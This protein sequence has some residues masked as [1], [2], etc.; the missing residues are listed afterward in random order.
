MKQLF[1]QGPYANRIR[2]A[3][4]LEGAGTGPIVTRALGSRRFRLTVTGPGG[5]SW[6]DHG[7]P[8]PI[9]Q[10]AQA[11]TALST[12]PLPTQ[13]RTTLNVG[14]ISGGTSINSIPESATALLDLRS[15]DPATLTQTESLLR[16]TL[17]RALQPQSTTLDLIGDRPAAALP[18]D[19]SLL[20][21]LR[22]TDRHL[23]LPTELRIGST[24]AN[25]PLSL[26]IPAIAI[27]TGGTGE[28]IHTLAEWYDPTGRELAL[29]RILLTLL[30][31]LTP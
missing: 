27:G 21:I 26:Q 18:D 7:T 17:A 3:I 12:I 25:I 20:A 1:L 11:L 15:T 29:R 5:H 8:N 13:P 4:A 19:S 6:T 9:L 14:H 23:H 16:Q 30:A 22:A 31:T 28:G 2:A 10:L 24:D